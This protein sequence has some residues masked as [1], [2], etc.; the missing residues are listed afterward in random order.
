MAGWRE[1]YK[2]EETGTVWG[3]E[4]VVWT[5]QDSWRQDLAH[6]RSDVAVRANGWLLCFSDLQVEPQYLW[7]FIVHA[8]PD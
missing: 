5:L 6:F 2:R 3:V 4:S 7:V 8:T 1:E